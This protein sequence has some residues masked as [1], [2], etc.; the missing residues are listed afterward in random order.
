M[1]YL[2]ALIKSCLWFATTTAATIGIIVLIGLMSGCGSETADTTSTVV[3]DETRKPNVV[4]VL[5]DQWRA[6]ATG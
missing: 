3:H 1:E 5:T 2:L 6:Q 4:F